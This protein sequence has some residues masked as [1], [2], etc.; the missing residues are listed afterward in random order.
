MKLHLLEVG[1]SEPTVIYELV[2]QKVAVLHGASMDE[3]TS[4]IDGLKIKNVIVDEIYPKEIDMLKCDGRNVI[5]GRL[6]D[7]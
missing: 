3:I 4:I 5:T 7:K 6:Y 1:Y 2:P